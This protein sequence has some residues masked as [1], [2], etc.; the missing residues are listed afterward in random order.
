MDTLECILQVLDLS[1]MSTI[2]RTSFSVYIYSESYSRSATE[3]LIYILTPAARTRGA[4]HFGSSRGRVAVISTEE[5]DYQTV[6]RVASD[7]DDRDDRGQSNLYSNNHSG[8]INSF[9]VSRK[10]MSWFGD[11]FRRNPRLSA[12]FALLWLVLMSS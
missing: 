10:L 11:H 9:K 12:V 7:G 6:L 5:S 4:P 2:A 3:E 8:K 1:L